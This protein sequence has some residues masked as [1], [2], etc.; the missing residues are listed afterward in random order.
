[1]ANNNSWSNYDF[2]N[3]LKTAV[4]QNSNPKA[5]HV[6]SSKILFNGFWRNGDKQNVCLWLDKAAWHDAKTGDGGNCKEF[7]QVAFNMKLPEFMERFGTIST[8]IGVPVSLEKAF[9]SPQKLTKPVDEIWSVLQK[10]DRNR[11]DL[12]AAW[13][14]GQRGFSSPRRLIGSGFANLCVDDIGLFELQHHKLIQQRLAFG[15]QILVPLRGMHSDQVHNLFFRSID[16]CPK[17]QKSRLL[18]GAGGWSEPDSSPRAFGFPHLIHD[19]PNLVLCEGMADYFAAECLLNDEH[20]FLPIGAA[21]ASAL[22]KWSEWLIKNGYK[23]QVIL[24]NQLDRTDNKLSND[25]IGQKTSIQ[26]VKIL[27]NH[28]I[29]SKFFPWHNFLNNLKDSLDVS[30]VFDIADVC[31]FS[32]NPNI[33]EFF[34]SAIKQSRE[35][36]YE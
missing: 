22:P 35:H 16:E 33:S 3:A 29:K 36:I 6:S 14:S 27:L 23:G 17:E 30:K 21:S 31:G 5:L 12:A 32:Q 24:L 28:G 13:L 8:Q 9:D 34:V 1:M 11:P 25:A 20:N 15:S 7:A 10:H 18:T 2:S 19:F 26:A 4:L